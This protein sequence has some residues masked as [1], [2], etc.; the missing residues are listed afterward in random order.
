MG[1]RDEVQLFTK[2]SVVTLD[3]KCREKPM[4]EVGSSILCGSFPCKFVEGLSQESA[5]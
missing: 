5:F 3:I 1:H 2:Q 4:E